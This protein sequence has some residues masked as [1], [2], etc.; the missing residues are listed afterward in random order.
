MAKGR[1]FLI[2]G[3]LIHDIS[4]NTHLKF[5][6]TETLSR[7]R[8]QT[9]E[10]LFRGDGCSWWCPVGPQP[11]VCWPG[12]MG[13]SPFPLDYRET[14]QPCTFFSKCLSAFVNSGLTFPRGER[15]A[16]CLCPSPRP[17]WSTAWLQLGGEAGNGQ[18]P[19]FYSG[20][21]EGPGSVLASFTSVHTSCRAQQH[22]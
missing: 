1:Y 19:L 10:K 4:H 7:P 14:D 15:N 17:A 9:K 2:W 12:L 20:A 11:K 18:V 13:C 5:I 22:C 16:V 8:E 3:P 21:H 6:F